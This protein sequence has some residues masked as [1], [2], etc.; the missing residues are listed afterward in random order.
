MAKAEFLHCVLLLPGNIPTTTDP[1]WITLTFYALQEQSSTCFSVPLLKSLASWHSECYHSIKLGVV[2]FGFFFF[3]QAIDQVLKPLPKETAVKV[4]RGVGESRSLLQTERIVNSHV[5]TGAAQL[6]KHLCIGKGMNARR[7][8][9]GWGFLS[10]LISSWDIFI[11]L[12]TTADTQWRIWLSLPLTV[13]PVS[14]QCCRVCAVCAWL[15][16]L[17]FCLRNN[18][19]IRVF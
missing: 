19:I 8:V 4:C 13:P 1:Y 15:P 2:K 18:L 12:C 11:H 14:A 17:P 6:S 10:S 7:W 5:Q 16:S 9:P 3:P